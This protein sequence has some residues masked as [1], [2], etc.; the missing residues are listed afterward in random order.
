VIDFGSQY[1]IIEPEKVTKKELAAGIS[2]DWY[3][4]DIYQKIVMQNMDLMKVLNPD[5][6]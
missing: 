6:L 1:E 3:K 5:D 4:S 2:Q